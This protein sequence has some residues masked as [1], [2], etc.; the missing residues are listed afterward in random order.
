MN[1]KLK[2][3]PHWLGRN[4]RS[5]ELKV[6]ALSDN[7]IWGTL[8]ADMASLTALESLGLDGNYV[9]GDLTPILN[10]RNLKYL[11]AEN[12][13]F[14]HELSDDSFRGLTNLKHLDLSGNWV[15]GSIPTALFE[16]SDLQVVDL[17][18]C[19]ITV[20]GILI[21][22]VYLPSYLLYIGQL[23][24]NILYPARYSRETTLYL[25]S[26]ILGTFSK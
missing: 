23:F 8:P 17:H 9:S 19:E 11:Y 25:L 2:H 21:T 24:V 26:N 3:M 16:M 18:D 12:N 20:R 10:L 22:V 4:T 1:M 13:S 14:E 5:P 15:N 7:D 6:L